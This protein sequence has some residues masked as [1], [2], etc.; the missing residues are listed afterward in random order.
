MNWKV[1]IPIS[2]KNW[3]ETKND[4]G[5]NGNYKIAAILSR[6][7]GNLRTDEWQKH[8]QGLHFPLLLVQQNISHTISSALNWFTASRRHISL[9]HHCW[10]YF[11]EKLTGERNFLFHELLTDLSFKKQKLE[12]AVSTFILTPSFFR[13]ED[14]YSFAHD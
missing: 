1:S 8:I 5:K 4:K 10:Q 12:I 6:M 11:E 3:D 9:F 13:K 7:R 14:C 2:M